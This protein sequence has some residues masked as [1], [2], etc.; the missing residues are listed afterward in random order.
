MKRFKE[1]RHAQAAA[2]TPGLKNYMSNYYKSSLKSHDNSN[3]V[4]TYF[5]CVD[6]EFRFRCMPRT[7]NYPIA[8][9]EFYQK[10]NH[11][12][13]I[14]TSIFSGGELRQILVIMDIS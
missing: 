13:N 5:V 1:T 3:V 10:H 14:R 12:C 2:R 11:Q 4:F 7:W 8:P 6:I 9:I